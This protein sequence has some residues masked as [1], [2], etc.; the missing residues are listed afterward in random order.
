[1]RRAR[2]TAADRANRGRPGADRGRPPCL[3]CRL[4]RAPG[5][6]RPRARW[7]TSA[8]FFGRPST[9][10]CSACGSAL[11]LLRHF[12]LRLLLFCTR[13][14]LCA[15]ALW[16]MPAWV[17]RDVRSSLSFFRG[18]LC[19]W[20][21]CTGTVS[22]VCLHA[23]A[24]IRC[25]PCACAASRASHVVCRASPVRLP[26]WTGKRNPHWPPVRLWHAAAVFALARL[27]SCEIVAGH[28]LMGTHERLTSRAFELRAVVAAWSIA[29]RCSCGRE[30][31]P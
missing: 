6:L 22:E 20:L 11:H 18:H 16:P 1:M 9:R 26:Q 8:F 17:W 21:C 10:G 19:C 5:C 25:G 27:P 31:S 15:G 23:M 29:V 7:R 3:V 24:P 28:P 30:H 14:P 4:R 12:S 2:C 13:P